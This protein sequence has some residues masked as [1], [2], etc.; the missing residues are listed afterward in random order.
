MPQQRRS[1]K[2]DEQGE[3]VMS[4]SRATSA[5]QVVQLRACRDWC[6]PNRYRPAVIATT[7]KVDSSF[8]VCVRVSPDCGKE[9]ALRQLFELF[10][11]LDA[12]WDGLIGEAQQRISLREA[13]RDAAQ[14]LVSLL[15]STHIASASGRQDV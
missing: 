1:G 2:Q 13:R 10:L 12:N 7:R 14:A 4:E 8:D 15:A 3:H 9:Q 11:H 5:R 6:G